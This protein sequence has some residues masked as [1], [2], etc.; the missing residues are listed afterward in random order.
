MSTKKRENR[1]AA[2]VPT[3]TDRKSRRDWNEAW[4][5]K[6]TSLEAAPNDYLMARSPGRSPVPPTSAPTRSR[7]RSQLTEPVTAAQL[8]IRK[9]DRPSRSQSR[10]LEP[11]NKQSVDRSPSRD[12][13][14]TW[15]RQ[16][17]A[18]PEPAVAA[19][20][21]KPELQTQV[22]ADHSAWARRTFKPPFVPQRS[23]SRSQ[24]PENVVKP[25]EEPVIVQPQPPKV[26]SPEP[27][28]MYGLQERYAPRRSQTR[29]VER[30]LPR[31]EEPQVAEVQRSIPRT[32][33]PKPVQPEETV[34]SSAQSLLQPQL[35][36][37]PKGAERPR[38]PWPL[39]VAPSSPTNMVTQAPKE[40]QSA[41][42]V[43][44]PEPD[45][46]V[47]EEL[48]V[49]TRSLLKPVRHHKREPFKKE[50][51]RRKLAE[52]PSAAASLLPK[53][54]LP[55]FPNPMTVM[56]KR[57]VPKKNEMRQNSEKAP[58][59]VPLS[60][61]MPTQTISVPEKLTPT[62]SAP[63]PE[64]V[65]ELKQAPP[66]QP[67]PPVPQR[68]PPA[69]KLEYSWRKSAEAR[70]K[71]AV[72]T[73]ETAKPAEPV[74]PARA[75][76]EPL[77]PAP[78]PI[79][80]ELPPLRRKK[81]EAAAQ[82]AVKLPEVVTAPTVVTPPADPAPRSRRAE[83]SVKREPEV[84]KEVVKKPD[85]HQLMKGCTCQSC[86]PVQVKAPP[87][88]INED[89]D[90]CYLLMKQALT[91]AANA[92][93]AAASAAASEEENKPEIEII[94]ITGSSTFDRTT[95]LTIFLSILLM[96]AA[97]IFLFYTQKLAN[98]WERLD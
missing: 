50:D 13:N 95:K 70:A 79:E 21:A 8:P 65:T 18:V 10:G 11:E 17:P 6:A 55:S 23:R 98:D 5:G 45:L 46:E 62:A 94:E 48:E 15:P 57:E 73:A 9:P 60:L 27:E 58:S 90:L 20:Q 80:K 31:V 34:E 89:P 22:G 1:I 82:P 67:S 56:R 44:E 12:W 2:N 54:E 96:V 25:P 77:Q 16:E 68:K 4:P 84:K 26:S 53:M 91:K 52:L 38:S 28:L 93:E 69:A 14:Q 7:S 40:V 3:A 72:E 92:K 43:K 49:D 51:F 35:S 85:V 61:P 41:E 78:V 24:A 71:V 32:E 59:P 47:E 64:T 33:S 37:R 81:I 76:T 63:V 42:K 29:S 83:V 74:A 39:G 75:K 30:T 36:P 66:V 97:A 88:A 86:R 87:P 19:Q